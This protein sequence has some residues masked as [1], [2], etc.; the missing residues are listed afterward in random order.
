MMRTVSPVGKL[1]RILAAPP[2]AVLVAP[3][4]AIV[5]EVTGGR[6]PGPQDW[7]IASGSSGV[8]RCRWALMLHLFNEYIIII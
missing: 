5:K 3:F 8:D 7:R 4:Y 6:Y 1:I 2:E